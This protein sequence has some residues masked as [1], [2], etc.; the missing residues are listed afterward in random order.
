MASLLALEV[1]PERIEAIDISNYGNDAIT[2]GLIAL[3]NGKF[4]KKNYRTYKIKTVTDKPD[5][6][7]SMREAITRRLSHAD[8]DPLPDLLL[9]D[10]GRTHVLTVKALLREKGIDLPVFGMVKDEFHKTRA[11]VD[12]ESEISIAREHSVFVF[13][14][15]IQEE[16]HRFAIKT[17]KNAKSKTLTHSSLEKIDGIGVKKAAF[18]LKAFKTIKAIGEATVAELSAVKGISDRDARAVYD[19][20]HKNETTDGA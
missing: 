8:T 19:H 18:L 7:A 3:E 20:F 2:A 10:G 13:I 5:D 15:K 16:V 17:M 12:E 4:S 14:Y 11:L 9:L 1:V 6:Y